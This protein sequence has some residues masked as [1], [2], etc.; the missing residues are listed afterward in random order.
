MTD[1]DIYQHPTCVLKRCVLDVVANLTYL[2][3]E[4]LEAEAAHCAKKFV[5]IPKVKT[6]HVTYGQEAQEYERVLIFYF[7][8]DKEDEYVANVASYEQE[9]AVDAKN[10]FVHCEI[11]FKEFRFL[12][13]SCESRFSI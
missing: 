13:I 10:L 7:Q 2:D 5:Q 1:N 11:R 9:N 8:C 4:V 6:H 12:T 3:S